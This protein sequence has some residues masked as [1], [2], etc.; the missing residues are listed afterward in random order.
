MPLLTLRGSSVSGM[1]VCLYFFYFICLFVPIVLR[2]LKLSTILL[3]PDSLLGVI[4]ATPHHNDR[5]VSKIIFIII[6]HHSVIQNHSTIN[7]FMQI[8]QSP[9]CATAPVWC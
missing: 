8:T 1:Y 5:A 7:E 6:S 2:P 3:L 9:I 4:R